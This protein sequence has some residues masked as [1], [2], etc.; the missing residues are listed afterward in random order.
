[1]KTEPDIKDKA[2]WVGWFWAK[3]KGDYRL[4]DVERLRDM[5]LKDRLC[6]GALKQALGD[7]SHLV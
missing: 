5:R 4:T 1:M 2:A 3:A 6:D 7:A